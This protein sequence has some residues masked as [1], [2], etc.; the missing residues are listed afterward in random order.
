MS[1]R[2]SSSDKTRRVGWF[3]ILSEFRGLKTFS[4]DT[5]LLMT[6]SAYYPIKSDLLLIPPSVTFLRLACNGS[7]N[8]F[9]ADERP[10]IYS[11]GVISQSHLDIGSQWPNLTTLILK[12]YS[13]FKQPVRTLGSAISTLPKDLVLLSIKPS[14]LNSD[15]FQLLPPGLKYYEQGVCISGPSFADLPKNLEEINF[16]AVSGSESPQD[17]EFEYL[18]RSLTAITLL[19]LSN[20]PHTVIQY[21]PADLTYLDLGIHLKHSQIP[22]ICEKLRKLQYLVIEVQTD[23]HWMFNWS[24]LSYVSFIS[25]FWDIWW[26]SWLEN[27]WKRTK[28]GGS[29]AGRPLMGW[30]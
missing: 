30:S 22:V 5:S 10:N 25:S 8:A 29:R 23:A 2:Y 16:N 21:L 14:S 11:D 18:P 4:Y 26:Y 28:P 1:F 19:K 20:I 15:S 17:F 24:E 9:W 3:S 13:L 12:Q 27:E 6:N 7:E